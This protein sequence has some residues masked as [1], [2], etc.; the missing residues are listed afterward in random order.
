M[1]HSTAPGGISPSVLLTAEMSNN[2]LGGTSMT[3]S[4]SQTSRRPGGSSILGNLQPLPLSAHNPDGPSALPHSSP[5]RQFGLQKTT[6]GEIFKDRHPSSSSTATPGGG[7]MRGN[8][9][10]NSGAE[11]E[12]EAGNMSGSK[13]ST[14]GGA[15]FNATI[16]R[17]RAEQ[18]AL[19]LQNRIQLLK[20][21]EDKALQ[22][23]RQTEQKA[24][25]ILNLRTRNN[26]RQQEREEAEA[27]LRREQ[28]R[29][30]SLVQ[31]RKQQQNQVKDLTQKQDAQRRKQEYLRAQ[32]DRRE[33]EERMRQE[34]E[35]YRLEAEETRQRIRRERLASQARQQQALQ[36]KKG[37]GAKVFQEKIDREQR[38]K[39]D[40]EAMIKEME[41]EEIVLIRKLQETQ[42]RQ[43]AAYEVL[44]DIM[45]QP[46]TGLTSRAE[47]SHAGVGAPGSNSRRSNSKSIV[48]QEVSERLRK[49]KERQGGSSCSSG[50]SSEAGDVFLPMLP[51]ERPA[52]TSEAAP[53]VVRSS[54][55]ASVKTGSASASKSKWNP[56][57]A[58]ASSA[59]KRSSSKSD[60]DDHAGV[61]KN[62][63]TSMGPSSAS[64][65]RTSG[66]ASARRDEQENGEPRK[67]TSA[68]STKG[69]SNKHGGAP[70]PPVQQSSGEATLTY[71]TVDGQKIE[72]DV[73]PDVLME[74]LE[75]ASMLNS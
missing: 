45:S 2:T 66:D 11:Q 6:P 61:R 67:S 37:I 72:I 64:R 8:Y 12:E 20:L 34:K 46:P 48:E 27:E 51:E 60:S 1:L 55:T 65:G 36:A 63:G 22:K 74:E 5:R 41:R 25:D 53:L 59:A 33:A 69:G 14:T 70:S 9:D 71:T 28:D 38:L 58:E 68:T 31:R 43:Q 75:L 13:S 10:V 21:E 3:M 57:E 49:I 29:Q 30:K 19:L 16:A 7:H 15:L 50:A 73:E 23:T 42:Q 52:S 24:G 40:K 62:S 4:A 54:G 26:M 32:S 18:D 47:S 44:E 17:K 39:D 56:T 35:L